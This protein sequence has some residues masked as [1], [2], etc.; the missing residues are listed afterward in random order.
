MVNDAYLNTKVKC[1]SLPDFFN[2]SYWFSQ[3]ASLQIYRMMRAIRKVFP[4]DCNYKDFFYVVLSETIRDVSWTRNS[5]FKLY[6]IP[7][8][9][10]ASYNK[11]T[12]S[13]FIQKAKRNI[14]GMESFI[15]ALSNRSPDFKI[16]MSDCKC[17]LTKEPWTALMRSHKIDLIITSPPYGDSRTT[18]D[19]GNFSRLSLQWLR[20]D[21]HFSKRWRFFDEVSIRS[22]NNHCLGGL[23]QRNEFVVPSD[24]L[25]K[26]IHEIVAL[27]SARARYVKQF[28][29]DLHSCIYALTR[30]LSDDGHMCFVIANRT[31]KG[32]EIP[33]DAIIED[34]AAEYGFGVT[35]KIERNIYGKKLPR[36]IN[37]NSSNVKTASTMLREFVIVAKKA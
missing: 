7:S 33:M 23:I 6:R 14:K 30:C 16:F 20:T 24:K 8:Q 4:R 36:K 31:V 22:I 21:S 9:S 10:L 12:L 1:S 5:E 15:D 35:R 17:L 18:V 11:N 26:V 34:F 32:V 28:F 13:L 29:I 37:T 19:Y 2:R 3:E 25:Q 27:D